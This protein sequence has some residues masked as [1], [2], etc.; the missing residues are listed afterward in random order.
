VKVIL[1]GFPLW[2]RHAHAKKKPASAQWHINAQ[3][4]AIESQ[5]SFA[6]NRRQSNAMH[7]PSSAH[8]R[9][10]TAQSCS[11][12]AYANSNSTAA[13]VSAP[14]CIG[15]TATAAVT[16]PPADVPPETRAI[17][18]DHLAQPPTHDSAGHA[19]AFYHERACTPAPASHT[20]RA[21]SA[22]AAGKQQRR[23]Q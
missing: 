21:A 14:L 23:W 22:H 6:F 1:C 17:A 15:L 4:P 20:R 16:V 8:R 12:P 9:T 2:S 7:R 10:S 13:S 5:L 3:P 19:V 18:A 11:A